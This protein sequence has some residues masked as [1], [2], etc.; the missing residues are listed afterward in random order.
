MTYTEMAYLHLATIVPAF[1]T[2]TYLIFR[3]KGSALH[4]F[5]G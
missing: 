3:P 1:M 4:R 5:L 2:G